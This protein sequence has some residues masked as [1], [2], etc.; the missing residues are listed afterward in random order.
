M[1]NYTTTLSNTVTKYSATQFDALYTRFSPYVMKILRKFCSPNS[2]DDVTQETFLQVY[3][4]LDSLL[5]PQQIRH[6]IAAIACRTAM[7]HR[8]KA[9]R[10]KEVI[11]NQEPLAMEEQHVSEDIAADALI[12]VRKEVASCTKALNRLNPQDRFII[13]RVCLQGFQSAEVAQELGISD[14]TIRSKVHRLRQTLKEES[15]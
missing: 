14:S 1:G 2:I 15:I 4:S 10:K 7:K 8:R 9:K 3:R 12:D 11:S 13:T 5:L 6:W